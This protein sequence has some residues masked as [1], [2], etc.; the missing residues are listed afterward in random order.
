MR[1]RRSPAVMDIRVRASI[2]LTGR[3]K[4]RKRSRDNA[5]EVR[6][7]TP[8][9]NASKMYADRKGKTAYLLS[10]RECRLQHI[11]AE[12]AAEIFAII[13]D[14]PPFLRLSI[15]FIRIIATVYPRRSACLWT[16][17]SPTLYAETK[18]HPDDAQEPSPVR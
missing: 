15:S 8:I 18:A 9:S 17:H 7:D 3:T 10:L 16:M 1:S 12:R 13:S 2:Q 11:C 6:N 4:R 14:F 5:D